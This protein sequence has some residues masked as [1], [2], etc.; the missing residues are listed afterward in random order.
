MKKNCILIFLVLFCI[1]VSKAQNN[2]DCSKDFDFV[3][4]HYEKNLPGFKDNVTSRTKKYYNNLKIDLQ[5]E[6]QKA[7]NKNNCYKILLQYVEFFK[8]NHSSIYMQSQNINENDSIAV[9]EFLKSNIYTSRETYPLNKIDT[10]QYPVNDIRGLYETKDKT[11]TIAIIP[12]KTPLRDYIGVIVA[13]KTK[14]WKKGQVKLEFKQKGENNNYEAI[15]YMRNHSIRYNS[16]FSLKEG[17]LGDSWFKTSLNNKINHATDINYGYDYKI[18]NDSISYLKIPTF[19]GNE[20]AKIDSLYKASFNKIKKT[21]YLIIDVRN[22]G[23][24]S[25]SNVEP[26]LEFIYTNKIKTDKLDLYVTENNINVWN[27][28]Y[29]AVKKDTLNYNK[30]RVKWFKNRLDNMKKAKPNSFISISKG[31]KKSRIFKPNSVKKVAVLYNKNCAS[32]CETLLFDAKQSKKTILVGENS[33]GYV[34]YGEVNGV[35]TPCYK[36][37]LTS[38]MTRYKKQRKYEVIGITPDYKLNNKKDWITQTISIL[39]KE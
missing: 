24:G 26:L 4:N 37:N 14:L 7:T 34:G 23:G 1:G 15:V 36:F 21:P 28:W 20:T 6:A 31:G 22:N 29:K 35:M 38:T 19:S 17:I 3:V 32:S 27:K 30:E 2:C 25:D 16:R 8:D 12:N 39:E 10:K 18:I 33:G 5:K 13:S 11:Y 9:K